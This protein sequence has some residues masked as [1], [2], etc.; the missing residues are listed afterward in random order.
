MPKKI[1]SYEEAAALL[2]DVQ[3]L[4]G[5]AVERVDSLSEAAVD[6]YQNVVEEWAA[7]VMSLGIE[8]KGLWLIDFDNGSGYYCWRWPEPSL[9]FFHGYDEGFGGRVMLQ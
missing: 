9:Q 5:E 3:R 6:E 4:T 8:V 2:P 7:G 1:F